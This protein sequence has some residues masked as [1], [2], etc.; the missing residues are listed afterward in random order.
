VFDPA[1][2]MVGVK[3]GH[4]NP[5]GSPS[6]SNS[7][8]EGLHN[9]TGTMFVAIGFVL[10]FLFIA[11]GAIFSRAIEKENKLRRKALQDDNSD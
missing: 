10:V 1:D 5:M 7:G 9:A 4:N 6:T 8:F 2:R 3:V 11:A